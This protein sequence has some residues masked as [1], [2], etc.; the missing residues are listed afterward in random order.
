MVS[1]KGY[2]KKELDYF[3]T[4]IVEKRKEILEELESLKASMMDVQT[5]EYATESST[6]SLH[7]EQGTDAMEREKVFL[8][9]SREGKFLNYLDDALKRI[10]TGTYGFCTDC[11]KLIE[12]ERLEA[13][14]HA[15]QCVQCKLKKGTGARL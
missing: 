5:G 6:Y 8:F 15:Q 3:K 13:V 11:G 10:E 4:I 14:P 7:M 1:K 2:S 9:A 12:K